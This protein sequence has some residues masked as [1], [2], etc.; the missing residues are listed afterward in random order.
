MNIVPRSTR[1]ILEKTLDNVLKRANADGECFSGEIMDAM[2]D[3]GVLLGAQHFEILV[4]RTVLVRAMESLGEDY[5][6]AILQNFENRIPVSR[7][8]KYLREAIDW[9]ARLQSST[10][11]REE[12]SSPLSTSV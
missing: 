7:A 5:P 11:I 6:S 2:R 9:T 3:A 1:Q 12:L 10:P 4:S 8:L